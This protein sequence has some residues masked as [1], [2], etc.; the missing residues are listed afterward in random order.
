MPFEPPILVPFEPPILVPFEP[1]IGGHALDSWTEAKKW[2]KANSV[3][4][5]TMKGVWYDPAN[6]GV[7]VISN[8]L[9]KLLELNPEKVASIVNVVKNLEPIPHSTKIWNMQDVPEAEKIRLAQISRAILEI[10]AKSKKGG[11]KLQT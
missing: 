8:I 6:T 5:H 7:S 9:S 3:N 2:E 1:P 11:E 10:E 4:E